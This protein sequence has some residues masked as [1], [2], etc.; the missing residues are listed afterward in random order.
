M[1]SQRESREQVA[2]PVTLLI[3]SVS[4]FIASGPLEPNVT[5]S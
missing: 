1:K 3:V 4:L 2:A 5:I